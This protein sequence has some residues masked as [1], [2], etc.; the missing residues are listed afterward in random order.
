VDL[1]LGKRT[2]VEAS[3]LWE[4]DRIE[5]DVEGVLERTT[6]H[7]GN[8]VG[9][10]TLRHLLGSVE[11]SHTLGAS[12]FQVRTDER[13]V[14]TR[15]PSPWTEP[16]SRNEIEYTQLAGQL[17]PLSGA[18]PA[19]WS[20]GYDIAWQH[21]NYDGPLPRYYAVRPDTMYRL[22]S[23]HDLRVAGLWGEARIALG[24]QVTLNP[25]L[26]LETGDQFVDAP[27]V[28]V[29]PRVALRWTLSAQQSISVAAGRSWQ[30]VQAIALAGPSIHPAFHA[31]HY[32]I[33]PDARTPAIRAD[34][35]SIGSE[36]WLGRGWLASASAYARR[37]TGVALPAPDTGLLSPRRTLNVYGQ[38]TARGLELNVR[39]LGAQWSTSFGY[40]FGESDMEAAGQQFPSAADRR[41]VLDA[42]IGVRVLRA[43]RVAAAYTAMSGAP[44][45]RAYS[46]SLQD[47]ALFGFGCGSPAGALIQQQ[48]AQRTPPYRSL[49]AS[50]H[51]GRAFGPVELSAYLQVRNV[52]NRDNAS[53]YS[54]STVAAR[55]I[56][57]P[58]QVVWDDRFEKGLPRLPLVGLRLT[59]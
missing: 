43:L 22:R 17:S 1:E 4:E 37:S 55:S 49:D 5:G 9:R 8:T 29:S 28:R 48:N 40:T 31:S 36:R 58:G 56:R 23:T 35:A 21:G 50:L 24:S 32:W 7:W 19:R 6:A 2:H 26:R 52:L 16:A 33:W 45:T 38:N 41:H 59:F 10:I 44:Y 3:G 30:Y 34:V 25:G 57:G 12:R 39:R 51:W 53:T 15:D 18:E 27:A 20:L 13:L 46:R 11:L 47:C 42:M 14:R 54:G